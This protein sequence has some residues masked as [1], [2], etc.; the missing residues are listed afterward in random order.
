MEC[1]SAGQGPD[2]G[3][4][5]S[6]VKLDEM[7][8]R[9]GV[10][11]C[12]CGP[13]IKDALDV[14]ALVQYA[15]SLDGVIVAK[16]FG[17]LCSS[18]G[19]RFIEQEIQTHELTRVVIAACSPKEH[20]QTFRQALEK[21]GL[22]PFLLQIAN[23]R[24]QC[25]WTLSDKVSATEKAKTVISGAVQRV[26]HH[27]PLKVDQIECVADV[28]VVGAGV[29]G[30]NAALT[31]SQE[32]RRVYLV[33]RLP[34]IG[35][36]A[37][38]YEDLFPSLE[39]ASCVLDPVLDEVLHDDHIEVLTYAE[40][41]EV[42]G[43][44]GNFLVKVKKKARRV[45]MESCIGCQAC[46]EP[47]PVAVTNEF[48]EGLDTRKA[49]YI[50]YPGAL[51]NV[52]AID[53]AHCLRFQGQMCTACQEA[54]PFGAI[55]YE[56][57][58]EVVELQVGAVVLATGFDLLDPARVFESYEKAT[59]VYTGLQLERLLSA[60]GPTEGKVLLGDGRPPAKIALIHCVG[61]R[62]PRF[63]TYCSGVCC[64]YLTKFSHLLRER[65]P[66][67]IVT[68]FFSD[69]CLPGKWAQGFFDEVSAD[70][71]V[72]AVRLKSVDSVHLVEQEGKTFVRYVDVQGQSGS[73][74]FDMVVL[75][76]AMEGASEAN[77]I[78]RIFE[79]SLDAGNFFEPEDAVVAPVS[80]V[81]KGVFIAGCAQ[82]PKDVRASV[83]EGQGA[84]GRVLSDLLPGEKLP[85]EATVCEVDEGRCSGCK[86]CI[87]SCRYKAM[88]FD[89]ERRCV[90]V[91]KVLC[92]G[93]GT[94][95]ATCPSGA[96][97]ADHYTDRQIFSEIEG[98][99]HT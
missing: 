5:V 40:V 66:E 10:Y 62:T 88:D 32:G 73:V 99:L 43:F 9:I 84:A 49:V 47:C 56:A 70:T 7:A 15:S 69:L 36:K 53:T 24:E 78:A 92:R 75:A 72:E 44:Y 29:A 96:I 42:L 31:L 20:E 91:N 74:A 4:P 41:E 55:D 94:C 82:G 86:T 38:R 1:W 58:D 34:C 22:N 8:D 83:A 54:C 98:L 81:R 87:G 77:D 3:E 23:I 80:S 71:F 30:I 97:Q 65:C 33:E 46:F 11:I 25:A 79:L 95:A 35:G 61:S 60:T 39:C 50:P 52:A 64:T 51:P 76:P 16:P 21:A 27:V 28:L 63:R 19:S 13:N 59:H 45:D 90:Q 67:S 17:L 68:H 48:N 57:Q 93:C 14:D 6:D 89:R 85:L 12:E 37:A 26:I 2:C 18:E